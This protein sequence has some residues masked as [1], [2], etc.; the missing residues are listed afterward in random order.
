[1]ETR[2]A[3]TSPEIAAS[4]EPIAPRRLAQ[5][6]R[7]RH[8]PGDHVKQ[9][10]PLRA[11][12]HQH[13][14]A[15]IQRDAGQLQARR[16]PAET[17]SA[18][19]TR[20]RPAR[21]AERSRQPRRQADRQSGRQRPQRAERRR[22]QARGSVSAGRD[23]R[24]PH[25]RSGT[26]TQQAKQASRPRTPDSSISTANAA[27]DTRCSPAAAH[28]RSTSVVT[29]L[30]PC[31][32]AGRSFAESAA[33]NS[34]APTATIRERRSQFKNHDDHG[35]RCR[36]LLRRGTSAPRP[37]PAATAIDRAPRS[38]AIIATIAQQ[39][40]VQ[41]VAPLDGHAHVRA[42]ARAGENR[43]RPADRLR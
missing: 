20:P 14:A 30:W 34:A 6:G 2:P 28:S 15:P 23:Q 21:P 11:Q 38:S 37:R 36:P 10:V 32:A 18:P 1:M 41:D 25:W 27:S 19:E 29:T 43:A 9:D 12:Q 8:R 17:T 40:G 13:D 16:S 5:I 22:H 31:R 39:H 3:N 7:N 24:A 26:S 42:D 35:R 33:H 4:A